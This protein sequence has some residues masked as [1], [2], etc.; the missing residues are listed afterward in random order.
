MS[1]GAQ[2]LWRGVAGELVRLGL[3]TVVDVPAFRLMC[4][5]YGIALE[6]ARQVETEGLWT[7]DAQGVAKKHPVVQVLRDATSTFRMYAVEFGMTPSSRGRLHME[8]EDQDDFMSLLFGAD[9]EV[10]EGEIASPM[11]TSARNDVESDGRDG[12]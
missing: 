6:A 3:L 10:G 7:V 8:G 4:E 9:V 12:G 11:S 2:R 5:E 1:D